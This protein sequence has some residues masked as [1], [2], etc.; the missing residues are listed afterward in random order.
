[1]DEKKGA[2]H[3]ANGNT[4]TDISGNQ[5]VWNAR[6]Q[7]TGISGTANASFTYDPFG[8]RVSKALGGPVTSFVYDGM[9]RVAETFTSGTTTFLTGGV[10]EYFLRSD[11]NGTTTSLSDALGSTIATTDGS[12]NLTA[13]YWYDPYGS[14][15]VTGTP[16][17]DATQF[18]G[19]ENDGTGLY[20]YRARYYNPQTG[21]FIS[22]DQI[23]VGGGMNLYAYAEDT[24]SNLTDP[25]G[26]KPMVGL[27]YLGAMVDLVPKTP[28]VAV[29]TF[30][31][32]GT[33]VHRQAQ[34]LLTVH[35]LPTV[36]TLLVGAPEPETATALPQSARISIDWEPW[37]WD[38]PF[39]SRS[40]AI[41]WPSPQELQSS[42]RMVLE[43]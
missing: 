13:S 22:Q 4:V 9:N 28:M 15:T 3:D 11:G 25:S 32:M 34:T 40:T 21:R 12:G 7:L 1:M 20:Y 31:P 27:D 6:N 37:R 41:L 23:G 2:G 26:N 5:Y 8:R 42:F 38:R 19:R 24:P 17:G 16:T 33:P 30:L 29:R 36:Q 35:P 43:T 39:P 18:T 10:D 14:T